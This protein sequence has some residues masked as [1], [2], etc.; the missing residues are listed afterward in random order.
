MPR[1]RGQTAQ[2]ESKRFIVIPPKHDITPF[3]RNT[4]SIEGLPG[5]IFPIIQSFLS[6][7][8]YCSLMNVN[9]STFQP[10]KYETVRYSL[11]GPERWFCIDS[12]KD[13]RKEEFVVQLMNS[14]KDKSK[15]IGLSMI[16]V[17]QPFILKNAYLFQ[18]IYKLVI[19]GHSSS[20]FKANFDFTLFHH[21]QH[22]VLQQFEGIKSISCGFGDVQILELSQWRNLRELTNLNPQKK[23]KELKIT[24]CPL[25]EK[26]LSLDDIPTIYLDCAYFADFLPTKIHQNIFWVTNRELPLKSLQQFQTI[27]HQLHNNFNSFPILQRLHLFGRLPYS[28]RDFEFAQSIPVVSI[29]NGQFI[30]EKNYPFFPLFQGKELTLAR[31]NLSAWS[32]SSSSST[33]LEMSLRRL[34]KLSLSY[35]SGLVQLPL[36]PAVHTLNLSYCTDLR[37]I[38]SLKK[39]RSLSLRNCDLLTSIAS[40]QPSLKE[41]T[42]VN[43]RTLS[44]LSFLSRAENVTI[45]FCDGI[46]N[47]SPLA[48]VTEIVLDSCAGIRSV[49]GLVPN[50][51]LENR[52]TIAKKIHLSRLNNLRQGFESLHDIDTLELYSIPF[53]IHGHGIHRINHLKLNN[54]PELIDTSELTEIF[55]S[56]VIENC[57][58]FTG[59]TRNICGIPSLELI[60]LW[61]LQQ[62]DGLAE[63]QE[64]T[65]RGINSKHNSLLTA[66]LAKNQRIGRLVVCNGAG[67]VL[68]EFI[69]PP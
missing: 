41:V 4:S 55:E 5:I 6:E 54:L 27:Y 30:E 16:D 11:I 42:M 3:Q 60:S 66:D 37:S 18:G 34:L 63:H 45:R 50:N 1:T 17:K 8:E 39:L 26:I 43:C 64:V 13:E 32:F 56:L 29:T 24:H 49:E 19:Q 35:V 31:F 38:P 12:L 67:D 51:H 28:F 9:L 68:S 22:L 20:N 57:G 69:S 14:V 52:R 36:L 59:L 10:I 23:L 15:Q 44:E 2:L 48:E 58:K 25:L 33:V 62:L 21:L 47:L 40:E 65:V 46:T 61:K 7:S 53:M